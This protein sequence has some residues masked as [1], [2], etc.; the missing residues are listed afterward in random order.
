MRARSSSLPLKSVVV[1]RQSASPAKRNVP[2]SPLLG[3]RKFI[4][5]KAIKKKDVDSKKTKDNVARLAKGSKEP[6]RTEEKNKEVMFSN[7]EEEDAKMKQLSSKTTN[8]IIQDNL[9][10]NEDKCLK[11][12]DSPG[13]CKTEHSLKDTRDICENYDDTPII[14]MDCD[15]TSAEP[16]EASVSKGND[17]I[18]VKERKLD[19]ANELVPA[20]ILKVPADVTVFRGNRVVLRVGYRGHPE[21]RVKWLRAVIIV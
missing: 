18:E 9:V 19:A 16:E 13:A 4:E 11:T 20:A 5:K 8:E 21:P 12:S 14:C 2:P 1:K 15:L 6:K 17:E 10:E 3:P 7:E